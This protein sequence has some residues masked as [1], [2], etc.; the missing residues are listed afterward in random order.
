M[1]VADAV[2]AYLNAS[3]RPPDP[4]LAEMEEHGERDGI[5]IVVPSTGAFLAALTAAAGA[6][7]VVEVG[8]AIGV[9]TLHIAR[10][11]PE[12][13]LIVSFEVDQARHTAARGYLERA[14][15]RGRADLRLTD[16]GEGLAE[17]DPGKWD[18][19]FLDGLKG[20]YPRHLELALPLLR[21]GGTVVVDNTLLS[22]TVAAGRGDAHWT[23]DAVETMRR[24]NAGLLERDDMVAALLPVGDGLMMA[25]KR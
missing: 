10:S 11:L 21:P 3:R 23:D 16:A 6:R 22:G 24:F 13:G 20:D 15:V 14:G 7:R 19:V 9:S 17:L 1:I 12:D 2:T 4:V 18:M 5:P 8:T 25:V